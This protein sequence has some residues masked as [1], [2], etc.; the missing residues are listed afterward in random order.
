VK[1]EAR[2]RLVESA[3]LR[4]LG[5]TIAELRG[6]GVSFE[7][8]EDRVAKDLRGFYTR[9]SILDAQQAVS[10]LSAAQVKS[11]VIALADFDTDFDHSVGAKI[12]KKYGLTLR[13]ESVISDVVD[14]TLRL[15][16]VFKEEN[17]G[18]WDWGF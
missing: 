2:K 18:E 7:S 1:I 8:V 16:R 11:L 3:T 12:R 13:Q 5:E 6:Q 4:S 17:G 15:L 9:K 10:R 14:T